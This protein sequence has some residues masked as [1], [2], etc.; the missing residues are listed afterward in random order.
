MSKIAVAVGVATGFAAV[1][2]VYLAFLA[3]ELVRGGR[4]NVAL[5]IGTLPYAAT[6][7]GF[8]IA[9]AVAF[10]LALYEVLH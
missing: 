10:T 8:L 4:G 2:V 3:H 1:M 5:G 6:R 9:A 7:P